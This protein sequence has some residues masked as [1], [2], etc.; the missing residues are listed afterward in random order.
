MHENFFGKV[1]NETRTL[2]DIAAA[3][4]P[5]FTV[6]LH[7]GGN[8]TNG[9]LDN[10]YGSLKSK[11]ETFLVREVRFLYPFTFTLD[12]FVFCEVCHP[13]HELV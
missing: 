3:E 11:K 5:D 7:G 10:D 1:S 9:M 6:L 12:V 8:T 13:C 2:L 4:A